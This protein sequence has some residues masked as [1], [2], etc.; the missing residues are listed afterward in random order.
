VGQYYEKKGEEG[1][2][3]VF[4]PHQEGT[5]AVAAAAAVVVVVVVVVVGG[6]ASVVVD[7]VPLV[8]LAQMQTWTSAFYLLQR[9]QLL[10][11]HLHLHFHLQQS[12]LTRTPGF[13][14][15]SLHQD[16]HLLEH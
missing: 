11:T 14:D 7:C 3:E 4:H 8:Q 12:C 10:Q 5:F 15:Y 1:G 9:Q 13:Q 2:E 16:Y 6:G